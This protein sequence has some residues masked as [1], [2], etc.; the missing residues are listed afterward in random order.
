MRVLSNVIKLPQISLPVSKQ[1]YIK[2]CAY[3]L[4]KKKLYILKSPKKF[5]PYESLSV[6]V[7][8][9]TNVPKI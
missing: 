5:H 6:F 9:S 7:R 1:D 2:S 4:L 3:K 8:R